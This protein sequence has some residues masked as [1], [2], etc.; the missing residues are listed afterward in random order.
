MTVYFELRYQHSALTAQDTLKSSITQL[1]PEHYMAR[2]HVLDGEEYET[3]CVVGYFQT[4]RS[5]IPK[6]SHL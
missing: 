3:D 2:F 5:K 6:D 4:T 1:F